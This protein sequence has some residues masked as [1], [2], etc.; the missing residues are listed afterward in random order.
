MLQLTSVI[1]SLH[2]AQQVKSFLTI[3]CKRYRLSLQ[4]MVAAVILIVY[5]TGAI[6]IDFLHHVVHDHYDQA[7]HTEVLEQ[8]PCHRALFHNDAADGCDHN[9]HFTAAEKC[10][11]SHVV[12][13][14][15]QLIA[16]QGVPGETFGELPSAC[17]F[18]SWNPESSFHTR[19]LRGPPVA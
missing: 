6:S 18:K 3:R 15:L 5:A 7:A 1:T 13:Q 17:S 8:D 14:P 19:Y 11:F 9:A 16:P 2:Y 10:K 12:F 4:S